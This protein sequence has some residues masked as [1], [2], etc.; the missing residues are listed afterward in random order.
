MK[1]KPMKTFFFQSQNE[2]FDI[3]SPN[4]VIHRLFIDQCY[5]IDKILFVDK[6]LLIDFT[7]INF[8]LFYKFQFYSFI[9]LKLLI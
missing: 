1:K 4:K 9:Y 2:T 5:I 7:F 6:L 3:N 8:T